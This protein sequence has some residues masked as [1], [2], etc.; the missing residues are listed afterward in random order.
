MRRLLLVILRGKLEVEGRTFWKGRDW[1]YD[2]EGG[3]TC[4][5]WGDRSDTYGVL[6]MGISGLLAAQSFSPRAFG[7]PP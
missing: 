1:V 3:G 2:G 6:R 4:I 7:H 5:R